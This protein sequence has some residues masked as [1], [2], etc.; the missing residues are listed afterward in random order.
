V[1]SLPPKLT[2]LPR[3]PAFVQGVMNLRGQVLPVIDQV[4]RFSGAAATGQKRR[5]IVVRIGDLQAGFI[6]DAV[7]EILRVPAAELRAAPDLGNDDTRVFER[8]AN[9]AAQNRIVL[10]VS[11]RELLDRA[12]RDLLASLTTTDATAGS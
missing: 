3:A 1:I 6:V 7:S 8:V 10:I 4:Q 2:P 5:V 12:E 11:P 9:L